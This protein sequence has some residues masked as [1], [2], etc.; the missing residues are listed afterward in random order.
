MQYAIE[1]ATKCQSLG[2]EWWEEVLHP[3]NEDGFKRLKSALPHIKWTTG[4]V[5]FS[6][7]ISLVSSLNVL[8]SI[9]F[10]A[11]VHTIWIPQVD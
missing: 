3:D 5:R 1:L 11:R 6:R 10:I 8:V 7:Q 4:E 9:C 2:V